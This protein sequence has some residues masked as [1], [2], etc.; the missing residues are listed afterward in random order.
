MNNNEIAEF[1]CKKL[2]GNLCFLD[3]NN[4]VW[5]IVDNQWI[6]KRSVWTKDNQA[7]W[8]EDTTIENIKS[9]WCGKNSNYNE[10]FKKLNHLLEDKQ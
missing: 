8:L 2:E 6:G 4:I 5:K 10:I 9:W 3:C 1:I 7:C